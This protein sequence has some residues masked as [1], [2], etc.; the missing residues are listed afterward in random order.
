MRSRGQPKN[1]NIILSMSK[2]N[3]SHWSEG[4]NIVRVFSESSEC[5]WRPSH[6]GL[7]IVYFDVGRRKE[8]AL[9]FV[10]IRRVHPLLLVA[11]CDRGGWQREN[12]T[13][14]TEN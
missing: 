14:E 8:S 2:W 1:R 9:G 3:N 7:T 5:S 6:P 4:E 10:R 13:P 11:R 12:A